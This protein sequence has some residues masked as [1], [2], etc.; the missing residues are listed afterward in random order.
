MVHSF[1]EAE[2]CQW[3][4]GE[5]SDEPDGDRLKLWFVK[6]KRNDYLVRRHFLSLLTLAAEHGL[7]HW[8]DTDEGCLA[9]SVIYGQFPMRIFRGNK[10][11]FSYEKTSRQYA[12]RNL[13]KIMASNA[14]V[15]QK[16]IFCLP[17]VCSESIQDF[18]LGLEQ[19]EYLAMRYSRTSW[20]G[21]IR[22]IG[23]M[24]ARLMQ[25]FGRLPQRNRMLGRKSLPL[26]R[27]YLEGVS[28][29]FE[30]IS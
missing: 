29:Q 7:D 12:R 3:W 10:I 27:A 20:L 28:N 18:D 2:V 5:S 4:F 22:G 25:Q 6:D 17:L 14:H 30:Y 16:A 23:R 21:Y 11:Q 26:E 15:Y 24:N 8:H 9:L 13:E 1:S 19:L